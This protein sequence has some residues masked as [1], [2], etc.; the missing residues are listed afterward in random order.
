MD[1]PGSE[2]QG[3]CQAERVTAAL[4]AKRQADVDVRCAVN[5]ATEA[6]NELFQA[7]SGVLFLLPSDSEACCLL[8]SG[9]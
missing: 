2:H 1:A 5:K 6:T 4:L 8:G 9:L 7:E 3:S